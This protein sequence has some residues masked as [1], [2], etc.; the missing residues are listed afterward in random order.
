MNSGV[1]HREGGREGAVC[2]EFDWEDGISTVNRV[3][4]FRRP[5]S[6]ES[7]SNECAGWDGPRRSVGIWSLTSPSIYKCD[8]SQQRERSQL[9]MGRQSPVAVCGACGEGGRCN[10][11]APR[12]CLAYSASACRS[13]PHTPTTSRRPFTKSVP[14]RWLYRLYAD[15][16]RL[17]WKRSQPGRIPTTPSTFAVRYRIDLL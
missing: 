5:L 4:P 12:F 7:T 15:L 8:R 13:S 1:L 3:T 10:G 14:S 9:C 17:Q 2:E 16:C 11:S 6:S